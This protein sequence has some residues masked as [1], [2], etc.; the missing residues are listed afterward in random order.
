MVLLDCQSGMKSGNSG[1]RMMVITMTMT[2]VG[3]ITVTLV[4]PPRGSNQYIPLLERLEPGCVLR[5]RIYFEQ[6]CRPIEF[7]A[8]LGCEADGIKKQTVLC[9]MSWNIIGSVAHIRINLSIYQRGYKADLDV[10]Q[11]KRSILCT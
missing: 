3:L 2:L 5:S 1:E 8:F 7:L 6:S 4:G 11:K 10:V 9:I